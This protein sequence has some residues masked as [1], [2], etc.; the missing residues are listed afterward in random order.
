MRAS[1]RAYAT[2]RSEIIDWKLTPGTVLGEVELSE[3]LGVSRTPIREA[4][5]KLTAEGLTEP[6]SGRGMVV[7]EISLDHLN[8]LFELR[9]ALECRAAELA[10][11]RCE[12]GIFLA[13]HQQLTNA[14]ELITAQD[15]TRTDY[16]QLAGDL[17]AAVD[18]AVGNHYLNL[19]L[20]NLRVHLVRV[21]RLG[22]DNPTRLRDAA[23][24]HAAIALA[25]AHGN[26]T[27]ASAATTVHLDNSLRHLLSTT[28]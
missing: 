11:Q 8:E 19:A 24:E 3:R 16:Y 9:S 15:P 23:R 14:G 20:K 2:L 13:L 27:V 7:S 4:L 18:A 28:H 26:P 25:I 5:A 10:A 21:R 12:P 22:K 17:D 1:E 6:Q